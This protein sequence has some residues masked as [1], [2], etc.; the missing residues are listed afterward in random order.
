[1]RYEVLEYRFTGFDWE[2]SILSGHLILDDALALA[3]SLEAERKVGVDVHYYI[4]DLKDK[5]NKV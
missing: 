5:V 3:K 2:A 1:M 4:R